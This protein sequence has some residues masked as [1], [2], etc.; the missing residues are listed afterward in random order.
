MWNQRLF[1]YHYVKPFKQYDWLFKKFSE[2][3]FL[4]YSAAMIFIKIKKNKTFKLS[5]LQMFPDYRHTD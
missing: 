3:H 1:Y 5:E 4:V 2:M